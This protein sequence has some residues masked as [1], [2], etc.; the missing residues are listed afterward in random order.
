MDEVV[1][2]RQSPLLTEFAKNL[3]VAIHERIPPRRLKKR[4]LTDFWLNVVGTSATRMQLTSHPEWRRFD[5]VLEDLSGKIVAAVE[6]EYAEVIKRD[7]KN[8][9]LKL[10]PRVNEFEKLKALCTSAVMDAD[11]AC[12][13]GYVKKSQ[14]ETAVQF[15]DAAW[16][17]CAAPLLLVL[18]QFVMEAIPVADRIDKANKRK[19]RVFKQLT[20][21]QIGGNGNPLLVMD[22]QPV[23]KAPDMPS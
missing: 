4:E 21:Y 20:M 11:F 13:I 6:W 10:N 7:R 23:R 18:I 17:G 12:Y 1:Q 9:G 5:T 14:L 22:P 15:L 19:K 3:V 8:Q 2:S 16:S